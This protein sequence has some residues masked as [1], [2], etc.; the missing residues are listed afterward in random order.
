MEKFESSAW[1]ICFQHRERIT[2]EISLS[3]LSVSARIFPVSRKHYSSFRKQSH[4][5]G[6]ENRGSAANE[7]DKYF[8]GKLLEIGNV[9]HPSR[10]TAFLSSRRQS[11]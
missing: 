3:V 9:G 4:E 7:V 1:R 5:D 2:D 11:S 6:S 10:E 8:R